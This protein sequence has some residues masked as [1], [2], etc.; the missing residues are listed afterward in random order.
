MKIIQKQEKPLESSARDGLHPD[1]H[2]QIRAW[3][4]K[5]CELGLDGV[6]VW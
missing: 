1:Q 3:P 4:K 5:L 2:E 6:L